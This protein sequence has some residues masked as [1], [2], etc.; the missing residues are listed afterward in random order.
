V[1]TY[2]RFDPAPLEVDDERQRLAA[3]RD[4]FESDAGGVRSAPLG[5]EV[6]NH[7]HTRYSFS[8]YGPSSVAYHARRAGLRVVGSVDHESISAAGEMTEAAAICGIGSTVGCELRVSFDGTPFADKRLNNP[9]MVGNAYIVIHGVPEGSIE[10]FAARLQPIN[11][12]REARN[13]RQVANLNSIISP[14]LGTLDY[15]TDVRPLS[16]A[17]AGGSVTERHIL[18]A[19]A[20]RVNDE[21][22][23]P[24][25]TTT[26]LRD[27]L[28]IDVSARIGECLDNGDNPHRLYDLLG[29]FKSELVPR[30]FV[31][32]EPAESMPV[33]EATKM[34]LELGAIP[35]Y[36]YLGDVTASPTG[37][38]KAQ[39]FEDEYVDEL[40]PY[41]PQLG[42]LAIT[43]M[44]PR[45][46]A[47]QLARL[48]ALAQEQG[49][50]E[51]SGVDINSSRQSFHSPESQGGAF[52]H[53]VESTWALVGHE[54][55]ARDGIDRGIFGDASPVTGAPLGDRIAHFAELG[56]E[57]TPS[58]Q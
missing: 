58:G 28:G 36:S 40:V 1:N 11:A 56:R 54:I 45:N 12:A 3:L 14:L 19:L 43:Y 49:L 50:M 39:T 26:L 23:S 18:Y 22:S 30:F 32:P 37:D 27:R 4:A 16:W 38:K 42:F 33:A 35:A 46:T 48:Q 2:P 55:A 10:P 57:S 25:Q 53:L 8:P 13:R 24:D 47:A 7:V 9:D 52:T 44:P 20:H 34:A 5:D 6:N 17:H 29:V 41:L 31:S 15:D 51:I 21:V